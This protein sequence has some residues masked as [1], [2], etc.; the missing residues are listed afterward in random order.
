[1][2]LPS[3]VLALPTTVLGV[4]PADYPV[5]WPRLTIQRL[6]T[7]VTSNSNAVSNVYQIAIDPVGTGPR[8]WLSL[9]VTSLQ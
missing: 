5:E 1:M 7:S 9:S 6:S 2:R 8:T 3:F 4:A